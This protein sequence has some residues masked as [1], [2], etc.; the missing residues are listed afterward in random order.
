[1]GHKK[2]LVAMDH[3]PVAPEV[4]EQALELA[5]KEGAR[6]MIFHCIRGAS[7]A[8]TILAASDPLDELPTGD[9]LAEAGSYSD[10]GTSLSPSEIRD[11]QLLQSQQQKLQME[12]EPDQE[13][14]QIYCQQAIAQGVAA[15]YDCRVGIR[16][17]S[18]CDLAHDWEADL[19]VVGRGGLKGLGKILL[20]SVSNVGLSHFRES[21]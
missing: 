3:P 13:W 7:V 17:S 15:E 11:F 2:I 6:L 12:V 16:A 8:E 19:I 9:P 14:L 18:I 1:M 21:K 20:G 10:I 5:K 4:F